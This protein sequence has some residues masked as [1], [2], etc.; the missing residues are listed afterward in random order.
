MGFLQL[1]FPACPKPPELEESTAALRQRTLTAN[2]LTALAYASSEWLEDAVE[3][4]ALVQRTFAGALGFELDFQFL[5]GNGAGRPLGTE[6]SSCLITQT[7]ESGQA[8]P[9]SA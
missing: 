9:P 5:R 8:P 2:K 4:E 3:G 1:D 7:K 6:N